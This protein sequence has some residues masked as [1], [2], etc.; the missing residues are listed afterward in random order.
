VP[1]AKAREPVGEKFKGKILIE[2]PES[3]PKD[4]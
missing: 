4:K 2:D 1:K 3:P